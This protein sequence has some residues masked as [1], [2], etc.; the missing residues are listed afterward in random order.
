MRPWSERTSA[1]RLCTVTCRLWRRRDSPHPRRRTLRK[2]SGRANSGA[3]GAGIRG[4][5]D[6]AVEP[7]SWYQLVVNAALGPSGSG[8]P[9]EAPQSPAYSGTLQW[10]CSSAC[11]TALHH[12]PRLFIYVAASFY[13]ALHRAR[14]AVYVL[15]TPHT[16]LKRSL[17]D[18]SFLLTTP[19][20]RPV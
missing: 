1:S 6:S 16:G 15:Y 12:R 9:I 2:R 20:N 11:G 5:G 8:N 10:G 17:L 7:R 4:A 14:L 19:Q 3:G 18:V 13:S